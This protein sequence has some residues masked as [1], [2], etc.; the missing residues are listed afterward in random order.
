MIHKEVKMRLVH[1]AAFGVAALLLVSAASDQGIGDAAAREGRAL[2]QAADLHRR[3]CRPVD[4]AVSATPAQPAAA[5]D[6]AAGAKPQAS[7][8]ATESPAIE[9][10][11]GASQ[12]RPTGANVWIRRARKGVY[13]D[14]IDRVQLELNIQRRL[15][16]GRREDRLPGRTSGARRVQGRIGARGRAAATTIADPGWGAR[17]LREQ[18]GPR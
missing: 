11:R 12:G 7:R 16:A 17:D 1:A 3:R 6:A 13:R 15:L 18:P 2:R 5:G 8:A 4:G 9:G 10:R 14:V